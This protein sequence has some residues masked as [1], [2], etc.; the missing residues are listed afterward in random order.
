MCPS[1]GYTHGPD[2]TCHATMERHHRDDLAATARMYAATAPK[3]VE[4]TKPRARAYQVGRFLVVDN[5]E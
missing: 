3:A 4:P 2:A 5:A 1:C